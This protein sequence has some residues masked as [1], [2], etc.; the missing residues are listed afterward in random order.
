MNKV[1]P[2]WSWV[3]NCPNPDCSELVD[4]YDDNVEEEGCGD[5]SV[6]ICEAC[7]EKFIVSIR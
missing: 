7:G 2:E 3:A 4:Q 6:V 1:T 5:D